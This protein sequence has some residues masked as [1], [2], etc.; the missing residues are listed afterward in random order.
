MKKKTGIAITA[1]KE[2]RWK[3][4]YIR[5]SPAHAHCFQLQK[6]EGDKPNISMQQ[7]IHK[8]LFS[9]EKIQIKKR[10][11]DEQKNAAKELQKDK[12]SES[13]GTGQY[14]LYDESNLQLKYESLSTGVIF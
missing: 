7:A 13:N 2:Q 1:L 5:R 12:K 14:I 3:R 10:K 11:L 4:I 8:K 9:R 6:Q